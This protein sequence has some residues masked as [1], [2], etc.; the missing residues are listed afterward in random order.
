MKRPAVMLA[1]GLMIFGCSPPSWKTDSMPIDTARDAMI[2]C[3]FKNVS[4]LDDL[5]SDAATIALAL[6]SSCTNERINYAKAIGAGLD[7]YQQYAMFMEHSSEISE[8]QTV[9]L[10]FV[11]EYRQFLVKTSGTKKKVSRP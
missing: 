5:R 2:K 6:S 10:P 4:E 3:A 9:F 8:Q 11:L 7:N 1:I